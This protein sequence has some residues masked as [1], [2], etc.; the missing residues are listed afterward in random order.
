[1]N[2]D[3]PLDVRFSL[4]HAG[5]RALL[6][7]TSGRHV[8]I[9]IEQ[10]R[11]LDALELARRFFS[12]KEITAL[13]ALAPAERAS[14]FFRCWTRKEAFVKALGT[15]LRFPLDSFEVSVHDDPAPQLLRACTA[16]PEAVERWRIV[17]VP[18]ETGYV[19]ALAAEAGDWATVPWTGSSISR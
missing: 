19:A 5:E 18:A 3:I 16:L 6:A 13:Q 14:A 15:G 12:A 1:M 7:V 8:G 4:S 17:A 2:A 11:P 10:E 9:D